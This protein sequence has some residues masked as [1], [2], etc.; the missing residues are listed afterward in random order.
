MR[1]LKTAAAASGSS[2]NFLGRG[3][4][5]PSSR[6][7]ALVRIMSWVSVS[8]GMVSSLGRH[9]AAVGTLTLPLP[10]L[11]SPMFDHDMASLGPIGLHRDPR[12]TTDRPRFPA[13]PH[14]LDKGS[15]SNAPYRSDRGVEYIGRCFRPRGRPPFC[16]R[17]CLSMP[18]RQPLD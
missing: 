2:F 5:E 17:L 14:H 10:E 1:S 18:P 16:V 9:N 6:F 11:S 4:I 8:L 15:P 3:R 13:P 12:P 7:A